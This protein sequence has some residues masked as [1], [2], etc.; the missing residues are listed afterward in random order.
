MATTTTIM[1]T[2]LLKLLP[3]SSYSRSKK[4][5]RRSSRLDSEKSKRGQAEVYASIAAFRCAVVVGCAGT[6][7]VA[8]PRRRLAF[9]VS[10]GGAIVFTAGALATRIVGSVLCLALILINTRGI[11]K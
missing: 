2:M 5:R 3:N 4:S 11:K 7:Q 10:A 9:L 6:S 1:V 8:R